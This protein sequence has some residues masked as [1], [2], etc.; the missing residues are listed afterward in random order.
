MK[1]TKVVMSVVILL[2]MLAIPHHTSAE[3]NITALKIM[4]LG[5]LGGSSSSARYINDMGQV[6]GSSAIAVGGT[7]AFLWTKEDG[8]KD[9][10]TL[11]GNYSSAV[12][13]NNHGQA[14]GNSDVGEGINHPF[15]WTAEDGMKDLGSIGLTSVA[16][17]INEEGDVVGYTQIGNSI[18][19]FLWTEEEGMQDLGTSGGI[20]SNAYMIN[21]HGQI[22]GSR[23][24]LDYQEHAF[25]WT[26]ENGMQD[27]G[28]LGGQYSFAGSINNLGQIAGISTTA[29]SINH[30]FLWTSEEGMKDIGTLGY[31]CSSAYINQNGQIAGNCE[32]GAGLPP[33]YLWTKDGGMIDLGPFAVNA[34]NDLGQVIGWSITSNGFRPFLWTR[35]SGL[36][37]LGTLGGNFSMAMSINNQGQIVG[38]ST[39][40]GSYS[41]HAVLWTPIQNQPPVAD[42]GGPYIAFSGETITLNASGSSDP[43]GDPLTYKWDLDDDGQY[44][45][46]TGIT[47]NISFFNVGTFTVGLQVTDAGE[48]SDTDTANVTIYPVPIKIDIKPGSDVNPINLASN[49]VV[50]VAVLTTNDFDAVNLDP[51][52]VTFAGA[53]PVRWVQ[54]DVDLDGDMDL[55]FHF[56]T[57]ALK[58]NS[59]STEASLIGRTFN[60]QAV[61]GKDSIKIVPAI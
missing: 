51:A 7:H 55:L 43:D 41:T 59:N 14:V 58:L 50:P 23:A 16:S 48:L 32:S 13:I 19:G 61:E 5:T 35:E 28:T 57:Q 8:M 49:G 45:D 15:I 4:D 20:M 37:D 3:N 56:N 38:V 1:T 54:T 26:K 34:V 25:L 24:G 18:H 9:L 42:A 29:S 44:D 36:Q 47:T 30:V 60:G 6:V 11:G 12:M 17:Y 46:A 21:D 2:A 52:T 53:S 33:A 10:G 27:L 22:V 40:L 31:N 39:V